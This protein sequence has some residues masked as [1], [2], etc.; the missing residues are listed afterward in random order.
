MVCRLFD[1]FFSFFF[2]AVTL[3]CKFVRLCAPAG[4]GSLVALSH[5][6]ELHLD[7]KTR[8]LHRPSSALLYSCVKQDSTNCS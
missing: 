2:Q 1:D 3:K 5:L 6:V 7:I 4:L 8:S